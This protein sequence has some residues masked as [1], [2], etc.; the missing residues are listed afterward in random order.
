MFVFGADP[1]WL[2][3]PQNAFVAVSSCT[4]TS[5]P[6]TGSNLVRS[7]VGLSVAGMIEF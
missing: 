7:A 6:I 5:R 3:Q 1:K 2:A 4:C